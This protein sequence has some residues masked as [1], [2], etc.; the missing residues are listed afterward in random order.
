MKNLLDIFKSQKKA[1]LR[2]EITTRTKDLV[3]LDRGRWDF[4]VRNNQIRSIIRDSKTL[5]CKDNLKVKRLTM[6]VSNVD[7]DRSL[8]M[9]SSQCPQFPSIRVF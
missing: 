1:Q 2:G 4:V 8:S 6:I 9:A 5:K 3:T 7:S